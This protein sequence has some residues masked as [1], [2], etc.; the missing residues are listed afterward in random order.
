MSDSLCLEC[1]QDKSRH[2]TFCGF[3]P[4]FAKPAELFEDLM[5]QQE[6]LAREICKDFHQKLFLPVNVKRIQQM[7]DL[8]EQMKTPYE[9]IVELAEGVAKRLKEEGKL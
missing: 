8:C 3:N 7:K 2:K 9:A 4:A 6:A 5:T 1:G